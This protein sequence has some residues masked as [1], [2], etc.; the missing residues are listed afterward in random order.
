[1][2]AVIIVVSVV[3]VVVAIGK[4]YGIVSVVGMGAEG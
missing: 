1:M 2:V 3:V 4:R